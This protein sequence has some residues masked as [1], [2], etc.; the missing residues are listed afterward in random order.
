MRRTII[1]IETVTPEWKGEGF[2]PVPFHEVVSIGLLDTDTVGK[3]T[4]LAA[5]TDVV[6]F[7]KWMTSTDVAF[8]TFNGRGFDLPVLE[9]HAMRN[10]I[11]MPHWFLI[12]AKSWEDPR[13]RYNTRHHLDL[14]EFWTNSGAVR[15]GYSLDVLAKS[16]NL[17]GKLEVDGSSVAKLLKE[18]GEDVVSAYCLC[19]CL[20]TYFLYLRTLTVCGQCSVELE[21]EARASCVGM[22][23][24]A[25]ARWGWP[26]R[27]WLKEFCRLGNAYETEG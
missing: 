5:T 4:K 15:G 12:G 9:H 21:Q 1:D 6:A 8:C 20:D 17:P 2:P 13:N 3:M 24:D 27:D 11:R 14:R 19:D 7:L 23:K 22:V 18:E 26:L 25:T 10:G 16:I